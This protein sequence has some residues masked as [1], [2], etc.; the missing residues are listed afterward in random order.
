MRQEEQGKL[1]HLLQRAI[2]PLADS[3]LDHDLWPEMLRRMERKSIEVPW[4]DWA[5][6]AVLAG[7]ILFFPEEILRFLYH[8]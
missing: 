8:L 1:K 2:P 4:L 3:T 7:W 6:A 5:L